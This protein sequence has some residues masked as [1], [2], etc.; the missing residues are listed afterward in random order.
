[1]LFSFTCARNNVLLVSFAHFHTYCVVGDNLAE[2]KNYQKSRCP[3]LPDIPHT[4]SEFLVKDTVVYLF[5]VT[6]ALFCFFLGYFDDMASLQSINRYGDENDCMLADYMG[7]SGLKHPKEI[8]SG[9]G[10]VQVFYPGSYFCES[11]FVNFIVIFVNFVHI[12]MNYF[13]V[14]K[15]TSRNKF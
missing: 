12:F 8:Y 2:E 6:D 13:Y 9:Q 11:I 14:C 10:S 3:W 1:M 15:K 7:A 4:A 5:Y